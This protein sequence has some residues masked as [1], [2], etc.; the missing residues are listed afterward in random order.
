MRVLWRFASHLQRDPDPARQRAGLP[1]RHRFAHFS[2]LPGSVETILGLIP[3]LGN[4]PEPT[5]LVDG[6]VKVVGERGNLAEILE[7]TPVARPDV[8]R[9][10]MTLDLEQS[11]AALQDKAMVGMFMFA[12]GVLP[13]DIRSC[14]QATNL[15]ISVAAGGSTESSYC[16]RRFPLYSNVLQLST[17]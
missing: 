13:Q 17:Y 11:L 14:V 5:E 8:S 4:D 3:C 1:I 7:L 9:G 12:T 10:V 15:A 16:S 6:P 2:L